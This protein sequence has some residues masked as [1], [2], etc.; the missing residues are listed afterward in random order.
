[1]AAVQPEYRRLPGKKRKTIM[2]RDTA[3]MGPDHLLIVESTGFSE[4]Y[5]RFYYR[6]IQAVTILKTRK[7]LIVN[8]VLFALITGLTVWG[9]HLYPGH[10]SPVSV[11]LWIISGVMGIYLIFNLP[12]GASCQ[13]W[14]HTRVQKEKIRSLFGTRVAK[15]ALRRLVPAIEQAQGRLSDESAKTVRNRVHAGIAKKPSPGQPAEKPATLAWHRLLFPGTVIAGCLAGISI[16]YRSP[17]LLAFL[18]IWLMAGLAVAV[19]ASALQ[20]RTD[21][22]RGVRRI[23]WMTAGGY[24]LVLGIGYAEMM[25]Y[26]ITMAARLNPFQTQNQWEMMKLYAR[27]DVTGNPVLLAMNLIQAAVLIILGITG[28]W[29]FYRHRDY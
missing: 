24:L 13:V 21:L 25:V 18:S 29:L 1:M 26:W 16:V 4:T 2:G 15:K 20:S 9:I 28:G 11:F 19:I 5:K 3:W 27:M 22:G 14:I 12:Q 23:S 17:F 8:S 6:D 10:L 7:A